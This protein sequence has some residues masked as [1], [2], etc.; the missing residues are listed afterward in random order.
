MDYDG[1]ERRPPQAAPPLSRDEE[2]R[3]AA[4]RRHDDEQ[5]HKLE[6][7]F[8]A[9]LQNSPAFSALVATHDF[10]NEYTRE[11][12]V[13][14][15]AKSAAEKFTN[16]N[17][18]VKQLAELVRDTVDKFSRQPSQELTHQ[19]GSVAA[20]PQQ[21]IEPDIPARPGPTGQWLGKYAE[22][23][24]LSERS[25]RDDPREE[26]AR[27]QRDESDKRQSLTP[28]ARSDERKPTEHEHKEAGR[29]Q[30]DR[31][32]ERSASAKEVTE[33]V[34]E[35]RAALMRKFGD[36]MDEALREAPE[37]DRGRSRER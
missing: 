10:Y 5:R 34:S 6:Q 23:D 27:R 12:M 30:T 28:H 24:R 18:D 32:L 9:F 7:D 37:H 19:Q 35:R 8:L 4:Q 17:I 20:Q 2:E 1:F 29:E 15:A 11:A 26:I 3:I 16:Q 31:R 21:R 14:A 36:A 33:R 25:T 13:A 22:L